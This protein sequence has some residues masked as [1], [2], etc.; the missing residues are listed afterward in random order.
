MTFF[1]PVSGSAGSF[2]AEPVPAGEAASGDAASRDGVSGISRE[3]PF[4]SAALSI[5]ICSVC[6]SGVVQTRGAKE[7]AA[8]DEDAASADL[9][10]RE[11]FPEESV[12]AAAAGA[13]SGISFT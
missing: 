6:A 7:P 8:A 10:G 1:V 13:M 9:S 4:N 2:P 5:S 3:N 11:G 12:F